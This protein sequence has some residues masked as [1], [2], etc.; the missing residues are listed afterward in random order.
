MAPTIPVWPSHFIFQAVNGCC[1]LHGGRDSLLLLV[2]IGGLY[3]LDVSH[4]NSTGHEELGSLLG[5][6]DADALKELFEITH[7]P[8]E[9]SRKHLDDVGT[10]GL[11]DAEVP[12]SFRCQKPA[13]CGFEIQYTKL[14]LSEINPNNSFQRYQ[15]ALTNKPQHLISKV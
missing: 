8:L 6:G 4:P 2:R 9:L 3:Q 10:D 13:S 14:K 15:N 11:R 1:M 12:A 5:E 7:N